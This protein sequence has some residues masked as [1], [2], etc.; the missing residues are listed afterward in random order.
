ME[1]RMAESEQRRQVGGRML[2]QVSDK[3]GR[4]GEGHEGW[5]TRRGCEG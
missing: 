2:T 1:R 3:G 5:G 4:A